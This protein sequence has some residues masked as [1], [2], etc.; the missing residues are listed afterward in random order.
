MV[1]SEPYPKIGRTHCLYIWIGVGGLGPHFLLANSRKERTI[2][3]LTGGGG[4][5]GGGT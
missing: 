1:E 5:G 3:F 4:G 2:I